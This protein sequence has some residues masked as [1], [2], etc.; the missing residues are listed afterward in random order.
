[1]VRSIAELRG[2]LA[3]A[4]KAKGAAT[5]PVEIGAR[6][7]AAAADSDGWVWPVV[8]CRSGWGHAQLFGPEEYASKP[9]YIPREILPQIAQAAEGARFRRRHPL[10]HEGTGEMLPELV[11]GWIENAR[12]EEDEVRAEVHLLPTE[13]ELRARLLAARDAGK[14]EL[15][16]VSLLASFRFRVAKV[17]GK[18]ALVAERLGRFVALDMCAEPG[19]GGKFL[20]MRLAAS[21][22]LAGEDAIEEEDGMSA[23]ADAE[24]R[25]PMK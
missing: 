16:N 11:A 10:D 17:E 1:M 24:R 21:F 4:L 18:D 2:R 19:W 6:I 13:T 5:I 15:F 14:L 25:V 9:Q 20:S 7:A 23:Q 22:G 12:V 8:I 3:G